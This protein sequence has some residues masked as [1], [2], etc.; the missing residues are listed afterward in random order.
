[1]SDQRRT[2]KPNSRSQGKAPRAFRG[3]LFRDIVPNLEEQWLID[4]L[5]PLV[6]VMFVYGDPSSGKTFLVLDAVLH[7][8]TGRR[9]AGREVRRGSICYFAAEG[10]NGFRK[11]VAAARKELGLELDLPFVLYAEAPNLGNDPG[12][13]EAL[14]AE[15]RATTS[16]CNV[17]VRAVVLDTLNKVTHGADENDATAMGILISNLEKIARELS[18]LVIVLHHTGKGEARKGMRG[19]Q[20]LIGGNDAIWRVSSVSTVREVE[21]ERM[22]DGRNGFKWTFN[23]I[24]TEIGTDSRGKPVTSCYVESGIAPDH[25]ES[26]LKQSTRV[27]G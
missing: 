5:A 17:P 27:R 16:E 26:P 6:G 18:C 20:A 12:D 11:R 8:A 7:V 24:S 23:L 9:W 15:V 2:Y 22:K 3:T 14:I 4:E 13:V 10:G 21:I 25:P 1:M 19:S